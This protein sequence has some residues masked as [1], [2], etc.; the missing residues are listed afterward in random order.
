MLHF[1]IIK[2]PFIEKLIEDSA[3]GITVANNTRV[4]KF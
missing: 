1:E 3:A 2:A 4:R